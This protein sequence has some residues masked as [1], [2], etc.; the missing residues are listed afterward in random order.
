MYVLPNLV[1]FALP[2][3]LGTFLALLWILTTNLFFSVKLSSL[4]LWTLQRVSVSG[5]YVAYILCSSR[6][7]RFALLYMQD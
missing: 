2:V 3:W 1:T 6:R 7:F 5:L 4:S